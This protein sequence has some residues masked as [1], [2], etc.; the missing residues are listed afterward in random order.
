MT[1]VDPAIGAFIEPI[2]AAMGNLGK[3]VIR[4]PGR[5]NWN[6]SLFKSFLISEARNTRFEFR[7]ETFNSFNHTRFNGVST[8]VS[9]A[10]D[11]KT[12]T[13]NFG[14]VTSAWDPRELQLGAKLVF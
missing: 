12:I 10:T 14:D 8:G 2:P 4:G 11:G 9:F 13:N 6:M 3:G 7:F 5:G 1:S